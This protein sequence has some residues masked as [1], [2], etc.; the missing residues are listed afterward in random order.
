MISSQDQLVEVDNDPSN[1]QHHEHQALHEK[2][3]VMYIHKIIKK[4][5]KK[6]VGK[7]I[8]CPNP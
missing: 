7:P 5:L 1:H 3:S 4:N 2:K 6:T 8:K